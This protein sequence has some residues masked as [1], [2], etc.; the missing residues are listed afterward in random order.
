MS[1]KSV[2]FL[3]SM[4]LMQRV[5]EMAGHLFRDV[6]VHFIHILTFFLIVKFLS[7]KHTT[8]G[9]HA[10]CSMANPSIRPTVYGNLGLLEA[11]FAS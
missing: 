9:H 5:P 11:L 4:E 6:P 8:V 1:A 10:L 7:L 2:L 3:R